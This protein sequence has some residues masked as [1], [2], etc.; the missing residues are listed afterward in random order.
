MIAQ[1]GQR[2]T[3][4]AA[5][6]QMDALLGKTEDKLGPVARNLDFFTLVF[7]SAAFY[8]RCSFQIG[9]ETVEYI[10][11]AAAARVD[12]PCFLQYR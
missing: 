4:T 5:L 1:L 7:F 11:E 2:V 8:D 12:D 10:L 3:E 9:M 6:E